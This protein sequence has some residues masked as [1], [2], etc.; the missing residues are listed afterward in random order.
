MDNDLR[1]LFQA[2]VAG[3]ACNLVGR[4]MERIEGLDEPVGP[5][6][7]LGDGTKNLEEKFLI[8]AIHH[9]DR[10]LSTLHVAGHRGAEAIVAAVVEEP[11]S[12]R[13]LFN[14]KTE[15]ILAHSWSEHGLERRPSDDVFTATLVR[16]L[17]L[18]DDLCEIAWRSPETRRR[19]HRVNMSVALDHGTFRIVADV[20]AGFAGLLQ[21]LLKRA[22]HHVEGLEDRFTHEG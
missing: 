3:D 8:L 7:L 19:L 17:N 22:I 21:R 15:A 13:M 10:A 12:A 6:L 14:A 2:I 20:G 11:C 18:N 4:Q 1:I 9:D 5:W 16:L